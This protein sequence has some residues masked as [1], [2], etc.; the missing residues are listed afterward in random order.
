ML[1]IVLYGC[2]TWSLTLREEHRLR[3]FGNRV[4]RGISG[5]KRDKVAGSWRRLHNGDLQNLYSMPYIIRVVKSRRIRQVGH[6]ASMD[7]RNEKYIQ[8]CGQKTWKEGTTTVTK[9]LTLQ[10]VQL[11]AKFMFGQDHRTPWILVLSILALEVPVDSGCAS[12][13]YLSPFLH[14][15]DPPVGGRD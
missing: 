6:M 3:T 1:H 8:N 2:K 11:G 9:T 4:L 13:E 14:G 7:G 5:S 15:S 10:A 12:Y